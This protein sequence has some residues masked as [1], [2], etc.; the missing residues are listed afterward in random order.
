MKNINYIIMVL[1]LLVTAA[2]SDFL[3]VESEDKVFAD[4]YFK[5]EEEIKMYV[6]SFYQQMTPSAENITTADN[7]ADYASKNQSPRFISG[8]YTPLEEAAWNWDNLRNV[9]YFIVKM[10]DSPVEASIKN[11]Y[12][13]IARFFRASFYFDKIVR[14]GNVPWY[15]QPLSNKDA[16]LY[17]PQDPRTL[18]MDNVLADLK[19]ASANIRNGKDASATTIT[20]QTANA[21]AS[22]IC[23]F[24]GTFR[25]Y[26]TDLGLQNTAS[27]WLTEAATFARLVMDSGQYSL[28]TGSYSNLFLSENPVSDEVLWASVYNISLNRLHSVTRIFNTATT[29]NRWGLIRQFVNTYLNADGTRFTD[30]ANYDGMPFVQEV[31]GRD[32]R[33][34]A[35]IRTEGYRRSD[36]SLAPPNMAY[37]FTGYQISKFTLLEKRLDTDYE[38][39]NSIPILR[40]AEVLLNYAEAKAELGEMNTTVWNETIGALRTRAGVTATEPTSADA[41]LQ[42][43][44]FPE[45]SDAHLLEVRRERGIELVFEGFR[46]RDLLRWKKGTLVE[47]EWKGIYVPGL[48]T[49]MDLNNDG[50][51][52]VVFTAENSTY[53]P[54]AGVYNYRL[55]PALNK[56]TNGTSGNIVSGIEETRTFPDKKYL[57]PISND[58]IVLNN[59][60]VQNPGW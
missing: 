7:D 16:G 21:M 38:S 51:F 26:H 40:Y 5:S 30:T 32:P 37:T 14:Y 3:D 33:L 12:L 58:D 19:F 42:Q 4:S 9:N 17:K 55:N 47:M 20:R 60:L 13:G 41:Y 44:Y 53:T 31:T 15:D 23:L 28:Y 10:Q 2:C 1:S 45:I 59:N 25:K 49:P 11:H 22:R 46:Y 24:E 36:G 18:V 43:T 35:T 34:A 39:Y 48:D 54:P 6:Y 52:D 27:A 50:V 29:G 56:L 8:T 57:Y